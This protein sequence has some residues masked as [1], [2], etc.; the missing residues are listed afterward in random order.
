MSAGAFSVD[1]TLP[2]FPAIISDLVAPE[3]LVQWTISAFIIAAG[4]GQLIWGGASDKFGRKPALGVGL[5]VFLAG[6]LL[7]TL[8]PNISLLLAARALQGFGA[9][10]AIVSS[11]AIIRDLYSGDELARS[12]ALASAIFAAGPIL[13]PLAGGLIAE[14]AGWRS[15]FFVLTVY[16]LALIMV[17]TGTPETLQQ[18]AA[19]ALLPATFLRRASRMLTHPQSRHFLLLSAVISSS[20]LLI[21]ASL[22]II[23][24]VQFGVAGLLFAVFF[25]FH[26][27]G[28][29]LGQIVNRRLIRIHGPV[30]AMISAGVVLVIAS[31]LILS[32]AFFDLLNVYLMSALMF[33]FATSYLI[34]YSNSSAMVLDPHGDIAGFAAS[35]FGLVS[36]VGGSLIAAVI[37]VFTGSSAVAFAVSL[38]GVCT[39]SLTGVIW[40]RMTRMRRIRAT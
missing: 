23:Y 25:A 29:I 2:A 22:P 20:I 17:L 13:A 11:R 6:C 14:F 27:I 3:T 33:L 35:F 34:V 5:V 15:I 24:E 28:I 37:V 9:A 26:G 31:S 18:K 16:V 8:A 4:I 21:L 40:W 39:V 32:F 19:D 30:H 38:L 1:I 7:A 12:L 36:Q 10:A